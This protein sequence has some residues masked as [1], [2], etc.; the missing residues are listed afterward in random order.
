M[1]FREIIKEN[2]FLRD[3]LAYIKECCLEEID[4][5]YY[6]NRADYSG[7]DFFVQVP[8]VVITEDEKEKIIEEIR[9]NWDLEE[10]YDWGDMDIDEVKEHISDELFEIIIEVLMGLY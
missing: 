10:C 8:I 2:D 5:Q 3:V 1:A 9:D 6:Y 7:R 4:G